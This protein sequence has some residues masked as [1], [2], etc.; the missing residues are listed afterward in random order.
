MK[1]FRLLFTEKSRNW[2]HKAHPIV[3]QEIRTGL[4][5]LKENPWLGKIL[6]RELLGMFS[7]RVKRYRILYEVHEEKQTIEILVIGARK[8]IYEE[9]AKRKTKTQRSP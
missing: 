3:R 6:Q 2:I 1:P 5:D 8:T 7:L 4:K 9:T